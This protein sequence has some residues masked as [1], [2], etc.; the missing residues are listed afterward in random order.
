VSA[1]L[2]ASLFLGIIGSA[3]PGDVIMLRNGTHILSD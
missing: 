1:A 2:A 3:Q